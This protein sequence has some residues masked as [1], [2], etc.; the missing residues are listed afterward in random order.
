MTVEDANLCPACREGLDC[1]FPIPCRPSIRP[2][3]EDVDMEGRRKTEHRAPCAR[4]DLKCGECGAFMI[5]RKSKKYST[6]FYGCSRFPECK[7]AHGA[8]PDGRPKGIPGDRKT[9]L[10]RIRAH[11]FFD[12]I[13]KE[14]RMSRGQA[15]AWMRQAMGLSEAEAH[16]GHFTIAQCERLI[17]I[18]KERF[19]GVKSA[20]ERLR[21]NPYADA[22]TSI[23]GDDFEDLV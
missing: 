14:K 15:Y 21:E 5:L 13:W 2:V 20:W 19:P 7:G 3:V 11:S 6:P 1:I 4:K 16:I 23:F 9:N 8:H 22:D 12:R 10:A 18:I 17:T